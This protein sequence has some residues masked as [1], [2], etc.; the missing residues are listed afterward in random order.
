DVRS[1]A[2]CLAIVAPAARPS[3]EAWVENGSH[4]AEGHGSTWNRGP[5][6]EPDPVL[7]VE[8][9]GWGGLQAPRRDLDCGNSGTTMRLLALVAAAALTGGDLTVRG[10]GLNPSRL[11]Y[12]DVMERMGVPTEVAMGTEEL[13]EPVGGL[14]VAPVDRDHPVRVGPDE[15]PLVI[16]EVPVLALM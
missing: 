12:L 8:G 2:S 7:E 1:T 14:R 9:Q 15:L 6:G 4:A 11:G 5:H 3:L 13:G 10:V 16:D